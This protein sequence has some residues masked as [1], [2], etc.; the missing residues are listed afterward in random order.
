MLKSTRKE[1][2][3]EQVRDDASPPPPCPRALS[4]SCFPSQ[5]ATRYH[6]QEIQP[7]AKQTR[8][9]NSYAKDEREERGS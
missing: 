6:S 3:T 5:M 2:D 9:R 4:S 7:D 8:Y 1:E